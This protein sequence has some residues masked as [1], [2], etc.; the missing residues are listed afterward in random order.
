MPIGSDGHYYKDIQ[1]WRAQPK[2]D[3]FLRRTEDEVLYGG[4]A[5]GG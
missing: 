2:Q 5:G 4:A 3:E 1:E